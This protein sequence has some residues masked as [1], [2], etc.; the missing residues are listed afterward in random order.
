MKKPCIINGVHYESEKVA[1]DSLGIDTSTLRGRLR[2]PNFSEY[3]SKYKLKTALIMR[4]ACSVAG[5]EYKSVSSA[6]KDLGISY[7]E[8][9]SRLA[10]FDYPDWVCDDIPKKSFK[11]KTH[12]CTIG[13]VSYESESA[14]AKDL[15][16]SVTLL[17]SRLRSF[18][19]PN[20]NSKYRTKVK[21]RP[22]N[23]RATP[24]SINGIRYKSQKEAAKSL[25][26]GVGKLR[27]RLL[28]SNFPEYVSQNIP[29]KDRKALVPC[30]A[31]GVEYRSIGDAAKDLKIPYEEMKR[32]L[33]S[34]EYLDYVCN[35][36]RKKPHFKYEV[37]GKKYKTM[38]EIAE[39]EGEPEWKIQSRINSILHTE[40]RRLPKS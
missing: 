21:H 17:K 30:I 11:P 40:Y 6:A 12:P 4:L 1:A 15:G 37:K 3:V 24:C 19:F 33:V 7:H 34:E 35:K 39:N 23:T 16:V 22:R 2:S 38:R 32:R 36:Y 13:A 31:V 28:S 10:S 29:K 26:I 27:V 25:K 5:I 20:Y 8:M 18:N 14:A 9:K